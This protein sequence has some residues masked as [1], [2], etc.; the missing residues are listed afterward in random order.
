MR[1]PLAARIAGW[2]G[3]LVNTETL[4]NGI[5]WIVSKTPVDYPEALR[6]MEMRAAAVATGDAREAVW[7]LE[8]PPLYTAG[9]SA[10]ASEMLDPRFPVY[11]AGRGGRYTYHG[12]GQRVVYVII[13]LNKRG[14][15][16]RCFVHAVEGW[17]IAAL[18]HMGV[19]ARR[20]PGR[21]G[22][23]TDDPELG[24]AKIGA[25][26]IRV[27]RWVSLHGFAIN[28]D[29]DLSHFTGIVPCGISEFGVTSI[30]KLRNDF[31]MS[32]LD[33][34]IRAELDNFLA[35]LRLHEGP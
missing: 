3:G 29:P 8:H 16:V 35:K 15:D 18:A 24:E 23:W 17:M 26:G 33:V 2:Q 4:A 22:I 7:L 27:R 25:I 20:E 28:L 9:T 34:A 6:W 19:A 32:Q 5:D 1:F 30:A 10:D 31:S 14:R 13:D 21:I 12:P 11:P